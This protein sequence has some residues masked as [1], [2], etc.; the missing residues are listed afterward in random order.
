MR[1]QYL[2]FLVGSVWFFGGHNGYAQQTQDSLRA[3]KEII[4]V[5][6]RTSDIILPKH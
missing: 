1:V 5:K 2:F 3:L 6:E 4:V